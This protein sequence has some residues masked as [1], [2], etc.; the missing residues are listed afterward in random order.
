MQTLYKTIIILSAVLLFNSFG[1]AK[2]E[3]LEDLAS[4]IS[5]IREEISNLKPSKIQEVITI[6]KALQELDQVVDFANQ[7]L[8]KGNIDGAITTLDFMEKVVRDVSLVI[9]DQYISE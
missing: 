5:D 1:F 9:P 3:T 8:T 2:E 4:E 7:M 6:D